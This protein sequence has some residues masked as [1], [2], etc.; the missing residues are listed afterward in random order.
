MNNTTYSV[1]KSGSEFAEIMPGARAPRAE[2]L[3]LAAA[4]E[5]AD[6]LVKRTNRDV[7]IEDSDGNTVVELEGQA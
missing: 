5:F 1:R 3:T 7:I 6:Y 2:G 4:R